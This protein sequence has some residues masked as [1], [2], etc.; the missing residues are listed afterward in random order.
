MKIKRTESDLFKTS[1]VWVIPLAMY[2][3]LKLSGIG[4]YRE[5]LWWITIPIVFVIWLT[6][7][8]KIEK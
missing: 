7:N 3:F 8:W 4:F 6:A 1:Q 2:L 5:W